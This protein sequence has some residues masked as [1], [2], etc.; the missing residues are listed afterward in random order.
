MKHN[1]LEFRN[2]YE[3]ECKFLEQEKKRF[4]R[5]KSDEN[6][7]PDQYQNALHRYQLHQRLVNALSILADLG[8]CINVKPDAKKFVL[9]Q[10]PDFQLTYIDHVPMFDGA[11]ADSTEE[12]F[13]IENY[14]NYVLFEKRVVPTSNLKQDGQLSLAD[15]P[16]TLTPEEDSELN[17]I[18]DSRPIPSD[19]PITLD[20][21]I[22]SNSNAESV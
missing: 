9:I 12:V 22:N 18:L 10:E 2:D 15:D 11:D 7:T 16:T 13:V 19:S 14:Q 21:M 1:F 3:L 6:C 20:D 5:V 4:N 17:S 8:D